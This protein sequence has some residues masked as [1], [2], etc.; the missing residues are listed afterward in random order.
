MM[1]LSLTRRTLLGSTAAML[2]APGLA[3]AQSPAEVEIALLVP[4]S[5]MYSRFGEDM[6]QGASS[7]SSTSIKRAASRRLA[8]PS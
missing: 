1:D 3:R 7:A 4:I 8:A 6:R 5:G 2:A